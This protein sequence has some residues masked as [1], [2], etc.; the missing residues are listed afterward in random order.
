GLRV[1]LRLAG[2]RLETEGRERVPDPRNLLIVANH[3][4]HLDGPLL[5]LALGVD[6][7]VMLKAELFALAP[8]R[9]AMRAAGFIGVERGDRGRSADALG[10]AVEALASGRC[11]LAFPEGTRSRDGHLGELKKGAFVAAVAAGSRVVPVALFGTRER[12]PAGRA[13]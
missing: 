7:T 9:P 12:M 11:L 2:I 1:A 8:L 13:W 5:L 4:S 10:A 6:F 3:A